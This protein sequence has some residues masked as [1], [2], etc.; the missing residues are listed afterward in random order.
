MGEGIMP[1]QRTG[2]ILFEKDHYVARV[3]NSDSKYVRIHLDKG[4]SKEQA[5]A[6]ARRL[7][8]DVE[9]VEQICRAKKREKA[10]K[11]IARS[12][13]LRAEARKRK[14]I[15][16]KLNGKSGRMLR[17]EK[18]R[19]VFHQHVVASLIEKTARD[20]AKARKRAEIY[21]VKKCDGSDP[22]VRICDVMSSPNIGTPA[23]YVVEACE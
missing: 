1:R 3:L 22:Y 14:L 10:S 13:K 16:P 11:A 9:R 4:F 18:G 21:D 2:N 7:A 5:S 8:E 20:V 12:N 6:E 15:K 17:T 23:Q 19:A